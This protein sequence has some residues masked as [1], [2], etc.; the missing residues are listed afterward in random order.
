MLSEIRSTR[1]KRNISET[2]KGVVLI[3]NPAKDLLY[4]VLT[5]SGLG[6]LVGGA[7]VYFGTWEFKSVSKF[8]DA[9]RIMTRVPFWFGM[10]GLAFCGTKELMWAFRGKDDSWTAFF[11]GFNVG[12]THAFRSYAKDPVEQLAWSVFYGAVAAA[13]EYFI[14]PKTFNLAGEAHFLN[15]QEAFERYIQLAEKHKSTN[16]ALLLQ[17]DQDAFSKSELSQGIDNR[18]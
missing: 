3:R 9:K 14:D 8:E 15:K 17:M 16:D 6:V 12:I 2:T 1:D 13:T 10:Y 18:S 5:I 7:Q 4:S 11:A